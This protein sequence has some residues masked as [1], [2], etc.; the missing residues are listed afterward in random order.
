MLGKSKV[1]LYDI[2]GTAV[3]S[4]FVHA[5]SSY[6]ALGIGRLSRSAAGS[7]HVGGGLV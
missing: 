4:Y 1:S 5:C 6:V 2:A 3:G 7:V